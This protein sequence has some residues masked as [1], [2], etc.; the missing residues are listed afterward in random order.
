MT[1]WALTRR[2]TRCAALSSPTVLSLF[3]LACHLFRLSSFFR[4]HVRAFWGSSLVDRDS[5]VNMEQMCLLSRRIAEEIEAPFSAS[6]YSFDNLIKTIPS[7]LI[8]SN[9]KFPLP[10]TSLIITVSPWLMCGSL[11]N[12]AERLQGLYLF[13]DILFFFFLC[14]S[15]VEV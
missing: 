11:Q 12:S 10:E 9:L 2:L 13:F 3:R 8:G 5:R 6:I 4:H 7:E 15:S 14:S 1:D